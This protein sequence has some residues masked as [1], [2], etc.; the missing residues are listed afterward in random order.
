MPH[1][2]ERMMGSNLLCVALASSILTLASTVQQGECSGHLASQMP[3]KTRDEQGGTE[4]V[5]QA[6]KINS[7]V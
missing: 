3:N 1:L 6:S 4:E 5:V 2:M 7:R